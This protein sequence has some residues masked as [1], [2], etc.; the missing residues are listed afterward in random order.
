M[1][2][3]RVFANVSSYFL[4]FIERKDNQLEQKTFYLLKKIII[5]INTF[6]VIDIFYSHRLTLYILTLCFSP[7]RYDSQ[8]YPAVSIH[9][10][11]DLIF[12][13]SLRVQ[14]ASITFFTRR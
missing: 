5:H 8:L 1:H 14:N 10:D 11:V 9:L 3:Y 2:E 12:A 4:R 13:L 6:V 7:E